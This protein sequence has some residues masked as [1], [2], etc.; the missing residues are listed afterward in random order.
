MTRLEASEAEYVISI[1]RPRNFEDMNAAQKVQAFFTI[2]YKQNDLREKFRG[3]NI[4]LLE[5]EALQFQLS[6]KGKE[7]DLICLE[8]ARILTVAKRQKENA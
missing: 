6:V 5:Q 4:I 3:L 2:V 8:D 7:D 1:K